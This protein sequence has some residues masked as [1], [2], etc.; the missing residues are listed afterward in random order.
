[1]IAH[2]SRLNLK[3]QFPD[4]LNYSGFELRLV[5]RALGYGQFVIAAIKLGKRWICCVG[6]IKRNASNFN[7]N[8]KYEPPPELQ[9]ESLF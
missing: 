6:T 9:S 5:Y 2:Q 7:V 1:M 8:C 3:Q 4:D